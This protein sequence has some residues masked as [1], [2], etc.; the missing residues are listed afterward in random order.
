MFKLSQ[1][2]FNNQYTDL[3][4]QCQSMTFNAHRAIVCTQSPVLAA[5]C[6]GNFQESQTGTIKI[7][8]FEPQTVKQMIEFFYC[9]T[10]STDD[11][12]N[13]GSDS[14][15]AVAN[16]TNMAKLLQQHVRVNAIADYY[17]VPPLVA[18]TVSRVREAVQANWSVADFSFL[19]Q[20]TFATSG[21]RSIQSL[22]I[23]IASD[24]IQELL[25]STSFNGLDLAPDFVFEL[26]R[27]VVA[28]N[29]DRQ[30]IQDQETQA[31]SGMVHTL[32][33][34]LEVV[35]NYRDVAMARAS[36]VIRN[37]NSCV[38]LLNRTTTCGWCNEGVGCYI[39]RAGQMEEPDYI[40]RCVQCRSRYSE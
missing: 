13:N 29:R 33:S 20:E 17:N 8:G 15:A 12:D 1:I 35:R 24:R 30:A 37:I 26:L 16:P 21:D 2:L 6:K 23:S 27:A 7:E 10:Y 31:L 38:S 11:D 28:S 4:L 14:D 25:A 32:E 3:T 22:L 18:L 40:L 34:Q 5:A 39:A 36:R 19:V 9:Q